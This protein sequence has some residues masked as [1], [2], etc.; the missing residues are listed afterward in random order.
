MYINNILVF[1]TCIAFFLFL[2]TSD[3]TSDPLLLRPD[4]GNYHE[5]WN[6][7]DSPAAFLDILAPPY[8]QGSQDNDEVQNFIEEERHCDFF[9]VVNFPYDENAARNVTWLQ[10]IPTPPCYF[11]DFE[12]YCGP[13]LDKDE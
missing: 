4:K 6:T 2:I 9:K 11:C 5:I 12:P 1:I 13:P 7:G 3:S 10:V 8:N